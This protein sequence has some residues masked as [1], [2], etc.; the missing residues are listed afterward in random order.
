MEDMRIKLGI[1][2]GGALDW[3]FAGGFGN[4]DNSICNL[5]AGD[6]VPSAVGTIIEPEELP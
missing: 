3:M 5:A 2:G 4:C 6:G 1:V